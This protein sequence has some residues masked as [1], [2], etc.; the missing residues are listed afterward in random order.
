MSA[1]PMLLVNRA[2]PFRPHIP[3]CSDVIVVQHSFGLTKHCICLHSRCFA[4]ALLSSMVFQSNW[5][6]WECSFWIGKFESFFFVPIDRHFEFS[7]HQ[8]TFY[9]IQAINKKMFSC[10]SNVSSVYHCSFVLN[11]CISLVL[12]S[13]LFHFI[14]SCKLWRFTRLSSTWLTVLTTLYRLHCRRTTIKSYHSKCFFM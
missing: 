3:S 6:C 14:I 2:P 8:T 7:V 1:W 4:I 11:V 10:V 12:V 13:R 5:S 9:L